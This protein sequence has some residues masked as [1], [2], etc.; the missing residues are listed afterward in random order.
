MAITLSKRKDMC[1]LHKKSIVIDLLLQERVQ[2]DNIY[3]MR[4]MPLMLEHYT[5]FAKEKTNNLIW[6]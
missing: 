6:I 3:I 5:V 1:Y 2:M 4:T